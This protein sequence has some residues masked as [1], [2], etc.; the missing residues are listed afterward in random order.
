MSFPQPVDFKEQ[1][2]LGTPNF[3]DNL[4]SRDLYPIFEPS[5]GSSTT[6][7]VTQIIAHVLIVYREAETLHDL[8]FMNL[9]SVRQREIVIRFYNVLTRSPSF[10][11]LTSPVCS[12]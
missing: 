2:F 7:G 8:V 12:A 1:H 11:R 3:A 10:F 4:P 9:K 5:E 6:Y